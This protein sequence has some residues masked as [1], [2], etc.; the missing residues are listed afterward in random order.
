MPFYFKYFAALLLFFTSNSFAEVACKHSFTAVADAINNF[1]KHQTPTNAVDQYALGLM[2]FYIDGVFPQDYKKAVY[3]ITKAAEQGHPYAQRDL[4][5][6]YYK[7]L[8]VVRNYVQ[9]YKWALIARNNFNN[10]PELRNVND[11]HLEKLFINLKSKMTK[12]Q[13]LETQALMKMI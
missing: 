1:D 5:L 12:D 10:N 6:F 2:Y 7:G 8:G 11:T 3:W 4:S 9:S 13:I